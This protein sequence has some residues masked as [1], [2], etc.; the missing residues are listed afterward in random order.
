[1]EQRYRS[2][3]DLAAAVAVAAATSLA[4]LLIQQDGRI[5]LVAVLPVAAVVL[6]IARL[7]GAIVTFTDHGIDEVRPTYRRHIPWEQV[8][9]LVTLDGRGCIETGLGNSWTL[10]AVLTDGR[11]VAIPTVRG[12]RA[13]GLRGHQSRARLLAD[14]LCTWHSLRRELQ[15]PERVPVRAR[16]LRLVSGD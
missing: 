10:G 7:A 5:A 15:N 11:I 9:Q 13:A 16:T 14:E 4:V 6:M 8:A 3:L 1:M 2:G 12:L